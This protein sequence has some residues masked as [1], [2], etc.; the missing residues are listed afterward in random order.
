MLDVLL[1][2][3]MPLVM[4]ALMSAVAREAPVGRFGQADFA[5]YY[6]AA[7]V[8]RLNTGAWV[9][10]EV[11]FEIRQGTL[12]FHAQP[13]H[14]LV[15]YACANVGA[16][17]LRIVASLP[18]V[19]VAIATLGPGRFTT[20]RCSS[21]SSRSRWSAPG[22]SRSSPWPSSARSPSPSTRPRRSS[23]CG[24]AS[25]ACSPGTSSRSSCS[26]AGSAPREGAAVPLHA[27]V[28]GRA[29]HRHDLEA[30]RS[31]SFA[32]QWL[33]VAVLAVMK[34]AA[35]VTWRLELHRVRRVRRSGVRRY[36]TLLGIQVRA[37]LAVA[38]QYRVDFLVQGEARA[39]LDLLVARPDP[40]RLRTALVDR[41]AGL[42]SRR[43][44]RR[45]PAGSR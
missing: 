16:M 9:I 45:H 22:S 4:L 26:R 11:N 23:S 29:R 8:V 37:S 32:L 28:P 34:V 3:T 15:S 35:R 27:V 42:R 30:E 25:T 38:M 10:W 17:P 13:I 33:C 7:L 5:A 36:L 20:T 41:R 19:A 2:T 31:A 21:R 6:L 43:R 14:P 39:L 12:A 1:S 18:I 40:R 44:A 24:S